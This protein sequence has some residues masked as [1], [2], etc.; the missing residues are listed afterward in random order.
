[1]LLVLM[2]YWVRLELGK[3]R[4]K[5]KEGNTDPHKGGPH[6]WDEAF[7]FYW[8]PEGK[9]SLYAL[10]KDLEA[11]YNISNG[12]IND[13]VFSALQSG[14][15]TMLEQQQE[16]LESAKQIQKQLT[17]L[18]IL[19]ALDAAKTMDDA[20]DDNEKQAAR[21]SG[22]GYWLAIGSQI[23]KASPEAE[24]VF[25]QI[26]LTAE[27]TQDAFSTLKASVQSALNGLEMSSADFGTAL[28]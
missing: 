4:N 28:E 1:G 8:G 17:R 2:S 16:P 11:K 14:I 23:A 21:W 15:K 12:G 10:A 13:A 27:D 6:N 22:F 18:F 26:F 24:Q 7:A 19:A 20:S 9:H 5:T 25:K 3:A